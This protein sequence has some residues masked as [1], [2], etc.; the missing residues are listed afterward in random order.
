MSLCFILHLFYLFAKMAQSIHDIHVPV[1]EIDLIENGEVPPT[2]WSNV[3]VTAK[4]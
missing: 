2:G 4:Y 3:T 1:K